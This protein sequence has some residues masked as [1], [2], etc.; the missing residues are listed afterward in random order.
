MPGEFAAGAL[1]I[2]AVHRMPA[3]HPPHPHL[4]QQG[5]TENHGQN[6]QQDPQ[7]ALPMLTNT[8]E[9]AAS[10]TKP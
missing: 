4:R 10:Q 2:R 8:P 5:E 9:G 1:K 3:D 7:G 6:N